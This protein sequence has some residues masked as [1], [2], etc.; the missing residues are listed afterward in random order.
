MHTWRWVPPPPHGPPTPLWVGRWGG[1]GSAP[2]PCGVAWGGWGF[3]CPI[4]LKDSS[5]SLQGILQESLRNLQG[6]YKDS[7]KKIP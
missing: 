5:T 2:P 7:F 6:F 1:D 3:M 4:F